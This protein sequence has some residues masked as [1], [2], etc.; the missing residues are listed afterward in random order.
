MKAS[1]IE[2]FRMSAFSKIV[3][4]AFHKKNQNRKSIQHIVKISMANP[5]RFV[6]ITK[7]NYQSTVIILIHTTWLFQ[8][9]STPREIQL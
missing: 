6:R 2:V 7:L 4:E 3:Q 5:N 9:Y 1:A 8:N